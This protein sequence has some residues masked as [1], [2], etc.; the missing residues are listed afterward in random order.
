MTVYSNASIN[1]IT[2]RPLYH[3]DIPNYIRLA[4]FSSQF[5]VS[6]WYHCPNHANAQLVY[7]QPSRPDTPFQSQPTES[8]NNPI[9]KHGKSMYSLS[10]V[11]VGGFNVIS[12]VSDRLVNLIFI[13][14]L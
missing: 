9:T 6:I 2:V 7:R 10:N 5:H 4:V 13:V 1:R 14:L 11:A 12:T 8:C 3:I